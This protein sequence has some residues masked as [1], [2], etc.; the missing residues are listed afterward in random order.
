MHYMHTSTKD[1]IAAKFIEL[2]CN[3]HNP[4]ERVSVTKIVKTLDIDR[5]TFYNNFDNTTDLVIWIFRSELAEMLRGAEFYQSTLVYPSNEL[6]DKYEELPCYARFSLPDGRL[7][8]HRFFRALCHLFNNNEEYYQRMFS[9]PCYLD[10]FTYLQ[11]LYMPAIYDDI[12][13]MLDSR[14]LP[15]ECID[16][17]AEY[18]T[19]GLI[20][21][22]PY[23]Y[24]HKK[25]PLPEENLGL[26]WNYAHDTLKMTIEYA[27]KQYNKEQ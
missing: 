20:G 1:A 27:L 8:E 4:Y 3:S 14:E 6:H 11:T 25:Q 5:K 26:M 16:F 13:I 22:I 12:L 9:Y 7:D 10:F 17:L 2:V 15:K 24:S 19:M 21:R 18:H 23:H